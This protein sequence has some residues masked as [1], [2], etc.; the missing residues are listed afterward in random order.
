[1]K[2]LLKWFMI[3]R[4]V[5]RLRRPMS[6][7][8]TGRP[9]LSE[10]FLA[11][12]SDEPDWGMDQDLFRIKDYLYGA[13]PFGPETGPSS[14][15]SFHMAF[16]HE[17]PVSLRIWRGLGSSFMER[18]IRLFLAL[19]K[20]AL[21]NRVDY[22]GWRFAAW[23]AHYL[24]DLTQPYHAKALPFPISTILRLVISSPYS[25]FERR[26]NYLTNRHA[27]F[28]AAT[29]VL[30]NEAVKRES[31][32]PFFKALAG[33]REFAQGLLE[34]L[35]TEASKIPAKSALEAN[36]LLERIIDDSRINR[37]DY[38]VGEDTDYPVAAKLAKAFAEHPEVVERFLSILAAC[39]LE[40]GRVTRYVV[41][42]IGAADCLEK[43]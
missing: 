16:L 9:S 15:A 28:E 2:P 34:R 20:L 1:M 17:N 18:R 21:D 6:R 14:Q 29:H 32:H 8:G 3:L 13:P 23:A 10:T 36:R 40:T 43:R 42:V 7:P 26:K 33:S 5:V 41:K 38:F 30:L 24:Q 11:T 37:V 12:F 19:A 31:E 25:V 4:V 22:W 39:F 35:M 27:L